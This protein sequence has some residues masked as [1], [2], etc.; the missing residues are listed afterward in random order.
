[1]ARVGAESAAARLTFRGAGRRRRYA[2]CWQRR[3]TARNLGTNGPLGC[4]I[5]ITSQCSCTN[6]SRHEAD[7]VELDRHMYI[8]KSI[9]YDWSLRQSAR[10]TLAACPG[11]CMRVKCRSVGAHTTVP[12]CRPS[13]FN[14]L[15]TQP[16][17]GSLEQAG[18]LMMG[19]GV[20]ADSPCSPD[21]L[22]GLGGVQ[23]FCHTA[24]DAY[25]SQPKRQNVDL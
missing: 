21:P 16:A 6:S 13:R 2:Y 24:I 9:P 14:E 11:A 19:C 7:N 8:Q 20:V 25:T 17:V 5:R 12:P 3:P 22:N 18:A 23:S 4:I 1:M 15:L 10:Q